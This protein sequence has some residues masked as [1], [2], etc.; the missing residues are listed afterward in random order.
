MEKSTNKNSKI[1]SMDK[2]F[3]NTNRKAISCQQ[4]QQKSTRI[5]N[6]NLISTIHPKRTSMNLSSFVQVFR[7]KVRQTTIAK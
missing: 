3:T 7:K 1:S 2:K 5:V 6:D 4:I